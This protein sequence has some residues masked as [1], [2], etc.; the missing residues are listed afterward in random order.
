MA[1]ASGFEVKR[2]R[3]PRVMGLE[4]MVRV[5]QR[6]GAGKRDKGNFVVHYFRPDYS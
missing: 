2:F 4:R 3:S 1:A 5:T 6:Q